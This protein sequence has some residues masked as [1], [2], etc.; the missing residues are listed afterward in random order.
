MGLDDEELEVGSSALGNVFLPLLQ[1]SNNVKRKILDDPIEIADNFV[2][3]SV[4]HG[5]KSAN[6]KEVDSNEFKLID[7]FN[8][9]LPSI[10][11]I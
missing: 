6:K 2:D 3:L 11:S 1:K 5:L 9:K 4:S 10:D 8:S 7:F